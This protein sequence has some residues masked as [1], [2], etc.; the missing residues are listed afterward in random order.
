MKSRIIGILGMT[1]MLGGCAGQPQQFSMQRPDE[2][3]PQTVTF[4]NGTMFGGASGQQASSLAQLIV[5]SNNNNMKDYEQLEGA[6]SKNL[7]TSQHALQMLEHLSQQQGTGEI[8]LFFQTGSAT[9][10]SSGLQ[11]Q[12]LINFADY[13][14]RMSRGRKVLFV[15]IGSASTTGSM[16][17]NQRLSRERSEA[18]E[19]VIDQ[20]L[21]NVPHQFFKV[22]GIGD[23]YSPKNVTL[24]E[25]QRYQNVRIIAVYETDQIPALRG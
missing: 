1:A 11:Y 20:Y 18:P 22:Y 19:P 24:Q 17:I 14:S 9:L 7:Q 10:P 13:L 4:P 2:Q 21:V 12:R 8:T 3:K 5:D 25:D 23:M 6:A 16:S 15:M